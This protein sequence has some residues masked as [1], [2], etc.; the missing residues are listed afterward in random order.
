LG[1]GLSFG[2]GLWDLGHVARA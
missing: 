1:L 2:F